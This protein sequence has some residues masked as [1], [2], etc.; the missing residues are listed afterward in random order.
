[1]SAASFLVFPVEGDLIGEPLNQGIT[2][3]SALKR[4]AHVIRIGPHED[5]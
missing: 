5:R 4:K 3:G 2:Q 1:M